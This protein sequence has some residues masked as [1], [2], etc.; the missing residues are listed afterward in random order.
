MKEYSPKR[1]T[2]LVLTGSG[3]SGAYAAGVLKA[4]DESGVKIDLVVG[5]GAGAVVAAFAAVAGGSKLYGKGGFWE[6]VSWRSFYRLR[7]PLRVTL[8]LL[9][10]AFAVFLL[11]LAL[12]LLAGLGFPLFLLVDLLSPGTTRQ[13]LGWLWEAP[14]LLRLPYLVALAAPSFVLSALALL[15]LLRLLL[16][17]R[18]RLGELF[19]SV[20][21]AEPARLRLSRFLGE[22]SRGPALAGKLPSEPELG[23]RYVALAS[24]NLGQP[25]FR[26]L[27]L[28]VADL[29][30]GQLLPF[31]LLA[32]PHKLAFAEARSRGQR[33][34]LE[35]LPGAVDLRAAG[36]DA[37]LFD[38]VMTG[39]LPPLVAPVR[40][41]RFPRRGIHAG[42]TRRLSDASLLGECGISEALAAG[43]EQ[44]IVVTSA[45]AT[46]SAPRRRR[47][48]LAVADAFVAA[49]E[50]QSVD[51][52]LKT[53]E[54][55]NRMV[56]TLGDEGQEDG[57]QDPATGRRHRAFALYVIRPE[58]RGP[59]P[60]ELDG[61]QD[62]ATEVVET[63]ED[64]LELGYRDA[65]RS[66]VEPVV[67]AVPDTAPR[68]PDEQEDQAGHPV[69]L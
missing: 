16:R 68:A 30:S 32:D 50:R 38:A 11:P 22:V 12:A 41:V 25:G 4:L 52:E 10:F 55:M 63:A 47:G 67:G 60:L 15:T 33:S 35:G 61:T 28:R 26:E 20:I 48:A 17:D 29:D 27:I 36:Y 1:R 40:R 23:R 3:T 31:V 37:L 21:D 51:V 5:S 66:F 39:L 49:L 69:E 8:L 62:P 2:A 64:L 7:S 54:L 58:R 65:Y 57:W 53:V 6:G 24:D 42:E 46:A 18:K 56:V 43:A 19:E 44:V 13:L 45:P 14:S 59:G 9:G 34:R